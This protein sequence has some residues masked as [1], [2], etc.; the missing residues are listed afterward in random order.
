MIFSIFSNVSDKIS[1]F[2]P[3][4]K[5][6]NSDIVLGQILINSTDSSSVRPHSFT[7][8][9]LIFFAVSESNFANF[10]A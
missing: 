1:F 7:N 8:W 5:E 9:V 3:N 6:R 10:V 4:V 2:H